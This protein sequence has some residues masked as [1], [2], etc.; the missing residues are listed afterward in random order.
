MSLN[1]S[2]LLALPLQS[3]NKREIYSKNECDHKM[4]VK[5]VLER[6]HGAGLQASIKK[7]EF[8]VTHTK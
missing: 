1:Q 7:R 3:N 8:H 4:H 2:F 5:K 6:L